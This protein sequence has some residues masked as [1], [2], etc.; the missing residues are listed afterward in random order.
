MLPI[1]D[2]YISDNWQ[3]AGEAIV[4]VTRCHP[5]GTYTVGTYFV[6]TFCLGAK[7]GSVEIQWGNGFMLPL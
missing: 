1:G 5:Q 7:N 2:C 6:D 4:W 3:H